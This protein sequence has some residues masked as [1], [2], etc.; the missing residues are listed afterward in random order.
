MIRPMH[1]QR[2]GQS[3]Q[4]VAAEDVDEDH[5]DDVDPDEEQEDLEHRPE[6][7]ENGIGTGQH[8]VGLLVPSMAIAVMGR[9]AR[10]LVATGGRGTGGTYRQP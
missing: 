5:E 10:Y 2:L 4:V 7:V 9:R 6:D 3:A 1:R 8:G